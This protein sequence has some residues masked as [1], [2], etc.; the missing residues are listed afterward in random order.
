M[1]LSDIAIRRPVF[2]WMI[3]FGLIIFGAIAFSR[4][5]VSQLPDVDY[6]VVSINLT[7]QGAAPEVMETDVVDIVED[8]LMTIQ[9]VKNVSSSSR[10]SSAS[11]TVEFELDRN[12]DLAQQDVQAKLQSVQRYLPKDMDPPVIT[13][14][15]PEDSPIVMLAVES[16]TIA[17]QKIMAYVRDVLKDKFAT[18]EGVGDIQM[19]G[20]VDPNLRIWSRTK[21]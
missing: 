13:K 9:G 1:T 2:A 6:P 5:G 21:R 20:Y 18:V 19:N 16:N 11:I 17:P 8:A 3:M 4:M 15:N 7:E 10:N 14:T 12:I